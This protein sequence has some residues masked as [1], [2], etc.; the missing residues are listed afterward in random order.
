MSDEPAEFLSRW[1]RLKEEA[2]QAKEKEAEQP[3]ELEAPLEPQIAAISDKEEEPTVEESD[4][5]EFDDVNFD[6]LDY[7][8][9]YSRFMKKGVPAAIRRR[10]LSKL[11]S[12]NPIFAVLDGINDYDEDYTDAALVVEGMKSAWNPGKGYAKEEEA[13][14]KVSAAEENTNTKKQNEDAESAIQ[15]TEASEGEHDEIETQAA[16]SE[17]AITPPSIEDIEKA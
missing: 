4:P 16:E 2:R 10:A 15:Q 6:A 5:G 8:S 7:E 3:A 17:E 11:W 1:S 9:D 13:K 12:S 14:T